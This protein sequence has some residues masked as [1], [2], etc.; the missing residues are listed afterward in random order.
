V[1]RLD[2]LTLLVVRVG[3]ETLGN[4]SRTHGSRI[5]PDGSIVT[6]ADSA[7]EGR[8]IEALTCAMPRIPIIGEE[9]APEGG[10]LPNTSVF[11]L[12]DP[13]DGTSAFAAGR[14]DFTVNVALVLEG[15]AVMGVIC[16]PA[17]D[18]V[19]AGAFDRRGRVAYAAR[20]SGGG[21]VPGS[22]RA[23]SARRTPASGP[24][25]LTSER[26]GDERSAA[27]IDRLGARTRLK[28]SSALKFALIAQGDADVYPRFAPTMAWDTAAG[29]ALLEASGGALLHPDGRPFDHALGRPLMNG[30]FVA[31]GDPELALRALPLCRGSA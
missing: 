11:L 14:D 24:V 30:P 17:R 18:L 16:A 15:R 22:R 1:E 12:V 28:L 4:A 26:H 27:L 6:A 31:W 5:K 21:L 8:L 23:I 25:A 7:C 9:S 19:F 29:G 13:L 20:T 2:A 10:R 3:A